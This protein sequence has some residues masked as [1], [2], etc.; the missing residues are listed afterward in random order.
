MGVTD[1]LID[2]NNTSILYMATGDR[3][4]SHISSIGLFKSTD[5]GE[6]WLPTGLTFSLSDNEY[7][8][9][10]AFGRTPDVNATLATTTIYA[11]TNAEIKRSTDSGATWTNRTVTVWLYCISTKN[12]NLW[13][14]TQMMEIR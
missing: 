2:P 9:D 11:L 6:T 14:L 5:A 1:I 8:R 13:F 12:F 10:I 3:D 4:S 7:I